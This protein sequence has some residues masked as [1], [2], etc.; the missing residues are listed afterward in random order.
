MEWEL[1]DLVMD[2]LMWE[3][4]RE[5]DQMDRDNIIGVTETIIRETSVMA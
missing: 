5:T 1:K 4:I 3:I 2:R